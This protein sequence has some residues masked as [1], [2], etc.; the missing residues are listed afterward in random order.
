MRDKA[1]KGAPQSSVSTAELVQKVDFIDSLG[2]G[3]VDLLELVGVNSRHKGDGNAAHR[4]QLVASEIARPS[5][6]PV[7]DIEGILGGHLVCWRGRDAKR[8]DVR[9]RE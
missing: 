5:H 9:W 7:L 2:T 8:P 1:S 6:Q 4:V 3:L